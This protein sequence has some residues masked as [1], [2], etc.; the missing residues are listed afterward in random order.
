VFRGKAPLD[1]KAEHIQSY[2]STLKKAATPPLD[3]R[4][5]FE[6]TSNLLANYHPKGAQP[7]YSLST[8]RAA[9][10]EMKLCAA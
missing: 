6:T 1:E 8:D 4:W 2:V 7:C 3:V 5:D 10:G 9:C